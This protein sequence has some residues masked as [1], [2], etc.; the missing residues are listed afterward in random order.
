MNTQNSLRI[1]W[2]LQLLVS[3]QILPEIIFLLACSINSKLYWMFP[4]IKRQ[5]MFR[6]PFHRLRQHHITLTSDLGGEVGGVASYK[7]LQLLIKVAALEVDVPGSN[8]C[9]EGREGLLEDNGSRGQGTGQT[10]LK[11]R[12]L[13]NAMHKHTLI[14][15][16]W[17][18]QLSVW[19]I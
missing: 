6:S 11:L 17:A 8:S 10:L 16:V 13:I 19:W 18:V 4:Q 2:I 5:K 9:Q 1:L 14:M 3:H 15:H 12:Y 7:Q